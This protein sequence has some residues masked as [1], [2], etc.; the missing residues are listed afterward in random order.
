MIT[1]YDI[2]HEVTAMRGK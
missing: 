2:V 1:I